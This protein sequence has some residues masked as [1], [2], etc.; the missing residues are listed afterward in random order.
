[1]AKLDLILYTITSHEPASNK[2]NVMTNV[3]QY[4]LQTRPTVKCLANQFF[5]LDN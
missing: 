1:M 4:L 5:Y 2:T 3:F